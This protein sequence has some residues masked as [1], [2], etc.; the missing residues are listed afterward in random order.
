MKH[1]PLTSAALV[2]IACMPLTA[3]A[4]GFYLP[5]IAEA[6]LW[7]LINPEGWAV[8]GVTTVLVLVGIVAL[9]RRKRGG[10]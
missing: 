5:P 3:Q 7:L 6:L 2:L 1:L 10:R 4:S 9:I 8:L